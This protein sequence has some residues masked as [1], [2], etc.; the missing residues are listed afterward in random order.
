MT[1]QKKIDI[2][3]VTHLRGPNIWT[4]RPVIEAWVDIG[5][6]E[7]FPSNS[8]PGFYERLIGFLPSLV[9]HHCSPG[10]RGGFLQRVRDGTYA[11][12]IVEHTTLELQNLAGMR[13]GFGKARQTSTRGVYKIAFR[14][15]QEQVGREA[16]VA[17]RD[18]VVAAINDTSYDVAAKVSHLTEMVDDLCLGPS[19]AHIVDAATERRIPSIRL[20]DGNLVQLGYGINQR[21]I[22]TAETDQTSAIAEEIASDKD[23]TKSL[24]KACGVP[25]P[26]GELVKS[27]EQAWEAAQ[28]I[29]LPVV[30]KPYDGNHGRGVSLNLRTQSDVEG[31]Y[32]LAYRKGGGSS[33]IV[34]K[35]IPGNE[36][37][38]LV[39]GKKVVAAACGETLWVVGDGVS[40]IDALADLQINSDPRR[41]TTEEFPLNS[42]TPSESGEIILELERVGLTPQSVPG[43]DQKVLIQSNGNVAFDITDRL[44]PTVAA[45]AALAAR[46]VGLD[47]AGVD[48]VLE[49]ATKPM[50]S[51]RAAVIE[52]NASPGLLAHIKPAEG[53]GQP[54]GKAIIEHLFKLDRDG[55]IPIVGVTGTQKTGRIARLIAWLA[56]ISGKHVG[57]A[58]SEG[59]YLD[60]RQ[61]EAKDC[62]NW[63]AGQRLLINRSVQ[64]AV[65]ENGSQTI[66]AEGLAYDKCTVGVVT[67]VGWQSALEAFD[68][69]DAEQTFKVTR[70][71]VDVILPSGTAVLNAA[72]PQVVELAELCDGKVIFYGMDPHQNA[73]AE[74]RAAGEQVVFVRDDQIVLAHGPKEIALLPL[75]SLKPAK[76]SQ[77]EMVMAAVAAAWALNIP[78][79]LIGAG[80]RTF[81]SNP[82]KTPY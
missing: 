54:V 59:L 35:Y 65:F 62:A 76:A 18:L 69:Q 37:R 71:Q 29:G 57:L 9:E 32:A 27:A 31:A 4:Y 56:H 47:I 24:L 39:V 74:H 5:T 2:L 49:D 19:T 34:E 44:H 64:A 1:D 72:D 15:R 30:L 23:L 78:P 25:V 14:T 6:L 73:M 63:E 82:R 28:E 38:L 12:H 45:A 58:C 11:A 40:T 10:V 33:V 79:E 50:K 53:P 55:R 43:K 41:G 21:R 46:V 75:A 51:Q 80:L 16:L 17:A 13:T 3:R 60:G 81:E 7:D 20:T 8:I 22:W 26:E 48:M 70:T 36:H 68:I 52:V 61:V 67:D 42:V 77:P 66:L